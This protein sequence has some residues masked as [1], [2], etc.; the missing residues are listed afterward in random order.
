MSYLKASPTEVYLAYSFTSVTAP[1]M[2][3]ITGILIIKRWNI[4]LEVGRI[5]GIWNSQNVFENS[6]GMSVF[7]SA[8][9]VYKRNVRLLR[10]AVADAILW[11]LVNK[12]RGALMPS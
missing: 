10:V 8:F 1:T 9:P 4:D 7:Q 6:S 12:K 11:V 2:G 5:Y 3:V